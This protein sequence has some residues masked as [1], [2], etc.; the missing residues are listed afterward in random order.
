MQDIK[1]NELKESHLKIFIIKKGERERE[2]DKTKLMKSTIYSYEY[3]CLIY[4]AIH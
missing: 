2:R 3:N 4:K 1:K